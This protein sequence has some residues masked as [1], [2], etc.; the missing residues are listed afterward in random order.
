[1]N[2]ETVANKEKIA[3]VTVVLEDTMTQENSTRR[4]TGSD[5]PST[6]VEFGPKKE[7]QHSDNSIMAGQLREELL[8]AELTTKPFQRHLKGKGWIRVKFTLVLIAVLGSFLLVASLVDSIKAAHGEG[9]QL[10]LRPVPHLLLA[11]QHVA[12]GERNSRVLYQSILR[13]QHRFG[14]LFSFCALVVATDEGFLLSF[15]EVT[16]GFHLI[17]L[18]EV[19]VHPRHLVQ[20]P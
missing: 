4:L 1:M 6:K 16:S 9:H 19:R 17:L 12:S 5:G 15:M 8:N 2:S 7:R 11:F 18:A 13:L 10:H 20:D 14:N 3:P